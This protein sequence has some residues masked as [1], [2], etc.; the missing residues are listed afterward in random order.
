MKTQRRLISALLLLSMLLSL[1]GGGYARAAEPQKVTTDSELAYA[2]L[3]QT[4]SIAYERHGEGYA[5]SLDRSPD[6]VAMKITAVPK[7]ESKRAAENAQLYIHTGV[8]LKPNTAYRVS[9]S[10]RAE[11]AHPDYTV[12]FDGGSAQAAYGALEGRSIEAG[13]ID[14]VKYEVTPKTESGELVL[15]LL[16]GKTE[17]NTIRF[18]DLSV[19]EISKSEIG[20]NVV[21]VDKLDYNAPG[22]IRLWTHTDRSASVTCDEK[23]ATLTVTK[24]PIEGAEV[25]KIKL[26]VATGLKPAAGKSYHFTA[27]IDSTAQKGYEL[28]YNEGDTEKGYGAVYSQRLTGKSQTLDHIISIPKDKKDPGELILQFSLGK[29][30]TGDKVTLSNISITEA[31]M[32]CAGVLSD[33][34][35]FTDK[36]T[37]VATPDPTVKVINA[38]DASAEI[39][40]D[41]TASVS[42][43]GDC[44]GELTTTGGTA[45]LEVNGGTNLWDARFNIDTGRT[46]ASG[47]SYRVSFNVQADRDY[48]EYEVL[49]GTGL[50]GVDNNQAYG[51]LKGLSLAAGETETL[52]YI[53]TPK[54]SGGLLISLQAGKTD[55]R[56]NAMTVSGFKIEEVIA[57]VV[58]GENL[59][60]VT[61][62][63]KD[64]RSSESESFGLKK[65]H[66]R[67]QIHAASVRF[68]TAGT[69]R[70]DAGSF[71]VRDGKGTLTGNGSSATIT[72]PAQDNSPAA[73]QRGLFVNNLCQLEA[74]NSYEVSFDITAD[75]SFSYEVCYNKDKHFDD[76]EK[77]FGVKSNLTARTTKTTV[78]HTVNNAKAGKLLLNICLGL[79]PEGTNVTVSNI[80]VKKLERQPVGDNLAT[81]VNYSGFTARDNKGTITSAGNSATI[82]LP[83]QED[84]PAAWQRGLFVND[85]CQLE[86]GNSYEIS[87]D[88]T[89]S[90]DISYEVCYNKNEHF[91]DGKE[92]GFGG[93]Y[94]LTVG[95]TKTTVKHTVNNAEAG[96]LL[97]N[98]CLGLAPEGT[99]VT[100]SDIQVKKLEETPTG[101]DLASVTYPS[102][103]SGDTPTPG[104]SSSSFEAR[105]KKGTITGGGNSVTIT[106]PA[107][108]DSPAAWQRGLFVNNVCELEDGKSYQVSFDISSSAANA[109]F[110]VGYNKNV[111][112]GDG[113]NAFGKQEG[114]TASAAARRITQNVS[115]GGK[116]ILRLDLGLVPGG[117]AVTISNIQVREVGY[118]TVSE[119]RIRGFGSVSA[120]GI[121][122]YTADLTRGRDNAVL[123]VTKPADAAPT[124]WKAKL[125]I[126]TGI[127]YDPD[128]NYRAQ[129]DITAER[130]MKDFCVIAQGIPD[131]EDIRG[132][133]GL[134]IGEGETKTITTRYIPGKLASGELAL[135]L[136]LGN[137]DGTENAFT[138]TNVRVDEVDLDTSYEYL[139]ELTCRGNSASLRVKDTPVPGM[140]EAWK[141]KLFVD[142]GVYASEGET[143]RV[144][145]DTWS[146]ND[147]DF[148]VN[149]NRDGEESDFGSRAGLH[150]AGNKETPVE[151]LFTAEREG[152]L[153]LQVMLGR[154]DDPEV[155]SV[156]NLRVERVNYTYSKKSTLPAE[157]VYKAPGAVS[158]WAHEDYTT[159]FTGTDSA[160]T[161]NIT[162]APEAGAEPWKIKLF[163]DTGAKLQAGKYYKVTAN[164]RAKASQDYEI[165]YNNGGVE[166]G[167]DSLGGLRLVG[168]EAQ[169]VERVLSVPAGLTDV[170][171]LTLQFNLGKTTAANAITVSGV[172]VEEVPFTYVDMMS[173][174]FSYTAGRGVSLWTNPDYTAVLEGAGDKATVHITEVPSPNAEVWKTKLFVH[175]GAVLSAGKTYLVRADLLAA[176]GQS[177]EVCF[178]NEETEKGFDV[179][180]GQTIAAGTKTTV[181]RKISVPDSMTDA[182]EL[183][184]QFAVGGGVKNDITVSNVSVQE[185]NFGAG[186]GK[187]APDTVVGL[188]NAPQTAAGTLEIT[189]GKL[190]Y[191]MAKISSEGKDNAV[192]I[193]GAGLRAGDLYTVAFTARADKGLTGVLAL[194]QANGG[195]VVLSEPFKLTAKETKYAFTTRKPLDQGGLYDILWQFGSPDNQ[196]AGGA[197][198]E[199]SGIT[200]YSPAETLEITHG[201]QKVTVN[202]K[203]AAPDTYDI[204]GTTYIKLRDLALLLNDTDAQFVIRYNAKNKLMSLTTGKAYAPV[205]GELTVGK[206]QA[207]SCVRGSLD[208]AVNGNRVDLKAYNIGKNNFFRLCDLNEL[209]GFK[210]DQTAEN[211]TL[212]ITSPPTPEAQEKAHAYDLFFLPEV[213]GE[214]QP[215]VG[216]TMPFYDNGVYYIYYLKDGGDSYNHSVYLTT[217][218]DFVTYKEYDDPVLSASRED[219]QDNWIGTGS[220][221]KVDDG[222]YF[223]YTGF[224]A[225]GSQEYHEKIMVAKGNSPTSFEKVSGWEIVPP[226]ELG[227]KNDFRDPQAYY[228]PA[229]KTISLT[230]TASQDGKA[231]ILKY[232]LGRNLQ[233]VKYDGIIFTD[234]TG[235]FWNLECSDTFQ[236]GNKWYLTYSGQDDTLW[237]AVANSR[238]GPYSNPARL[239]GKLFYAAKHVEDGKN[240][241]MV[242]WARRAN[243]ASSTQEVAGWAGNVAVQKLAQKKDGSL[244]LVPVD[245]IVSAFDTQKPLN[246]TEVSLTAGSGRQYKAAFTSSESF[247]LKGEFTY[248]GAGSFGLAFDFNGKEDQY[249]LISID[250]KANKLNLAFNEGATPITETQ[251]VLGRNE[252]HSFTYIQDGSVGIF[253]LDGQAALL[254]RLYGVTNKPIYL[255]A[256]NNS[257]TFTSL[258][259]YTQ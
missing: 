128:K 19:D 85:L 42:K 125:F 219:V 163:L 230:V 253:Y 246:A 102:G 223:F 234:P 126:R 202:G 254:V 10:L 89:A 156:R 132:T 124:G 61:Y 143:Y 121:D 179:L 201:T 184:L 62:P 35:S 244:V 224:N 30:K 183:I 82:T 157:P 250:P 96:K 116:L 14:Q 32:H 24:G 141:V 52:S 114:L 226:A 228:D 97:L 195:T 233:D 109:V 77:V 204:N 59:A 255:F 130:A 5:V 193:A 187:P 104:P 227:Q 12:C 64:T 11:S 229:T 34:F 40:W 99:K 80:E 240:S 63:S 140:M 232:T 155:V 111:Q 117:T 76:G 160:I 206:N 149:Y 91:G 93:E 242:G 169:I 87:F 180:Y 103:G 18:S 208:V 129:F 79:A 177:Y 31:S 81:S 162:K 27:D 57:G 122:G 188:Y 72:L 23:S 98:I 37:T 60:D 174:D 154:V 237:Y 198:V 252:K 214:A 1:F 74:G 159:V 106:L 51:S 21:L 68:S 118:S 215:Y 142:T 248:S 6:S 15:R 86:A 170:N 71:E 65:A 105:D 189:R 231:R 112:F 136:E 26:L 158:Y 67:H 185:L 107:Q 173:K 48:A 49:Y 161:A 38:V 168:G 108:E 84:N 197:N 178:N 203:T 110:D 220:V 164:V 101:N 47:K 39:N 172:K 247:M 221:V 210:M 146:M 135:Q 186:N 4:A 243:S 153:I 8:H 217:T 245:S 175:T 147:I 222:Y 88:I 95:T 70:D 216:D 92:K 29:L 13:G 239:E 36:N 137:F 2:P 258:R 190:T 236:I 16:L 212:S 7:E 166:K 17:G 218:K 211:G 115:G 257:V 151:H 138:I 20:K 225:S 131:S 171:N 120:E 205:G 207:A 100:V 33:D 144:T 209:L 259:Q 83:K 134:T 249:K 127:A 28:C 148:E 181:E 73:W 9:F 165:C 139:T 238:F 199:I 22:F 192:T 119:E 45:T 53:I 176:N 41:E 194:K 133:W 69:A 94:N 55:G 191:K 78:K 46:L 145:F 25:W 182:G 256:E 167:Y 66:P 113:E 90:Q 196:K 3:S 43:S 251:A 213:D 152:T 44:A 54:K 200:V 241:Y 235:K 58:D 150:A 56:Y 123:K 50:N 75:K